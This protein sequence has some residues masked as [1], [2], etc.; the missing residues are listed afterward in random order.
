MGC[1]QC[2]SNPR[3][4]HARDTRTRARAHTHTHTHTLTHTHTHT[5]CAT[6]L[7]GD[8]VDPHAAA[9]RLTDFEVGVLGVEQVANA[10]LVDLEK[11][12]LDRKLGLPIPRDVNKQ[13]TVVRVRWCGGACAVVRV[14]CASV[15][16]VGA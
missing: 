2:S 1:F 11:R 10:L 16:T 13:L 5:W 12:A 4:T 6:Y 3:S 15:R 8:A 9:G 7:F 14:R